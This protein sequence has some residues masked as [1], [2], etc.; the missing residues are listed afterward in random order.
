[1]ANIKSVNIPKPCHESWQTMAPVIGG[2]H[3]QSCCKTVT[4]FT[5]M[6]NDEI[7]AYLSSSNNKVCGRIN[8]QQLNSIN[9][10][11]ALNNRFAFGKWRFAAL[12]ISIL[13]WSNKEVKAQTYPKKHVVPI[14]STPVLLTVNC[15]IYRIN[16]W[17]KDDD[18]KVIPGATILVEG[19]GNKTST[20]M[21]GS[22]II[23]IP[24]VA[25]TLVISFIGYVSQRIAVN[26]YSGSINVTLIDDSLC[27]NNVS[28]IAGGIYIRRPFLWRIWYSVKKPFRAIF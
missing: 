20:K 10:E 7:I 3:C 25:D 28:G 19:T 23:D 1:M 9:R 12:A 26:Q 17:V 18:G 22:F 8:D 27:I 13:I 5:I 4:D 11:L 14:K 16:G 24:S 6:N 2:R 15:I 21:D